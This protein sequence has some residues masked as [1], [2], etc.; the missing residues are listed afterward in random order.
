[1]N[2]YSVIALM[3]LIIVVAHTL[4]IVPAI[5]QLAYRLAEIPQFTNKGDRPALFDLA[6]RLAYLLVFVAV[7]KI[8]FSRNRDE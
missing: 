3:I 8:I 7:I 4:D 5:Q 2:I 1:M 6:V